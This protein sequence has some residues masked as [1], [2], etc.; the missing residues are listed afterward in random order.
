MNVTNATQ[1]ATIAASVTGVGTRD[2]KNKITSPQGILEHIK[3]F[4]TFGYL[5]RNNEHQ[6]QEFVKSMAEAL[7]KKQSAGSESRELSFDMQGCTVTFKT[8]EPNPFDEL[9]TVNVEVKNNN[10]HHNEGSVQTTVDIQKYQ[11]ICSALQLKNQLNIPQ[12]GHVLTSTGGLDLFE[13]DLTK[14]KLTGT[15]SNIINLQNADLRGAKMPKCAIYN[16]DLS[17]ADISDTNMDNIQIF[18]AKMTKAT[19]KNSSFIGTTFRDVDLNNS[20]ISGSTF[21]KKTRDM[22]SPAGYTISSPADFK[23]TNF[24]GANFQNANLAGVDMRDTILVN[25]NFMS[26]DIYQMD[27]TDVDITS[28]ILPSSTIR[29][30]PC[31]PL[32]PYFSHS[33]IDSL[34]NL[35]LRS[36]R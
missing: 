30:N 28:V 32:T 27:T 6:Y 12:T 3:N 16:I 29:P 23:K 36:G 35:A 17:C 5:R 10:R 9:N 25:T 11:Q 1:I 2:E 31:D 21:S 7:E 15:N 26:A 14:A 22:K 34:A 8:P 13:A 20:D 4:F 33:V 24:T 19:I 18:N